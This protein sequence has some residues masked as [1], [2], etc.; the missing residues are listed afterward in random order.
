MGMTDSRSVHYLT[1]AISGL[2]EGE[3]NI[4]VLDHVLDLS[5]HCGKY[6]LLV[7]VYFLI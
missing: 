3:R 6:A 4:A 2:S 7:Y 5:S 1:A